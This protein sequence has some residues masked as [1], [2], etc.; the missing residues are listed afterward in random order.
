MTYF[1]RLPLE[2]VIHETILPMLD[3]ESRIQFNHTLLPYERLRRRL[4]SKDIIQHELLVQTKLLKSQLNFL[5]N[6]KNTKLKRCQHL[7]YVLNSVRSGKRG[8]I[9]PYYFPR[10]REAMIKKFK[11]FLDPACPS[12]SNASPY[13]KKKIRSIAEELVHE[14]QLIEPKNEDITVQA[15]TVT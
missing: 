10:L 12:L 15:I 8:S 1:D 6:M 2:D 4:K 9:L 11:D 5:D 14:I 3:Y 7:C 13:F